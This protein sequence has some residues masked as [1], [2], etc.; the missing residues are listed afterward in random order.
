MPEKKITGNL[1]GKYTCKLQHVVRSCNAGISVQYTLI[2]YSTLSGM[3]Y[4]RLQTLNPK[5]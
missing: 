1:T 3:W 4:S 2:Q 5:P